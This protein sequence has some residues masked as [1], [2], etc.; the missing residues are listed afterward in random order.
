MAKTAYLTKEQ[1]KKLQRRFA[2]Y[3][4][5]AECERETGIARNTLTRI[6]EVGRGYEETLEKLEKF[7]GE[8]LE[9]KTA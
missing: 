9:L 5:M 6:M 3:G 1:Q 8:P 7:I 4:S 2:R